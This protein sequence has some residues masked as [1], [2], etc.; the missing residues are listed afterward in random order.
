M[1]WK[2][3]WE[4]GKYREGTAYRKK[5]HHTKKVKTQKDL[6]REA[7]REIEQTDRD[8]RKRKYWCRSYKKS[9]VLNDHRRHRR[10]SKRMAK[11]GRDEEL[12]DRLWIKINDPWNWD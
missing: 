3:P 2:I 10:Y 1:G 5:P 7:W 12:F 6:D 9:T 11:A 8:K 4:H